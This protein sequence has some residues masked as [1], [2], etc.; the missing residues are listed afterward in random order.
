MA[1]KPQGR[2]LHIKPAK[3][4]PSVL[5]IGPVTIQF[6]TGKNGRRVKVTSK[7]HLPRH[8]VLQK[9]RRLA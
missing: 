7:R 5:T 6:Q 9:E 8:K 4:W 2:V 1:N 3:L